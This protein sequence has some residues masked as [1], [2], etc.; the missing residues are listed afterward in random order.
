MSKGEESTEYEQL[1]PA[2]E[3]KGSPFVLTL[4]ATGIPLSVALLTDFFK[5]ENKIASLTGLPSD[6]RPAM[7][8]FCVYMFVNTWMGFSVVK[9]RGTFNVPWPNLYA[10]KSHKYANE[11][12]CV[13]RGH[14]QT[15]ES[16]PMFMGMLFI[17][18]KT[19]PVLTGICGSIWAATRIL[20]LWDYAKGAK[21]RGSRSFAGIISILLLSGLTSLS[22]ITQLGLKLPW[23]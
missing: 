19:Y 11:F 6:Y 18:G 16:V 20:F 17:A 4:G 13:Q 3:T 1:P 15:L 22:V 7:V 5:L 14:Q 23:H 10:D 21:K 2:F 8:A 9:A 12:N